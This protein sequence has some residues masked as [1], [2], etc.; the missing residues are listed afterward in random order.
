MQDS[1]PLPLAL[2]FL[3]TW[4]EQLFS[5][6][7]LHPW[8]PARARGAKQ[9]WREISETVSRRRNPLTLTLSTGFDLCTLKPTLL[10]SWKGNKTSPT[11]DII[12]RNP[13][14]GFKRLGSLPKLGMDLTNH[15]LWHFPFNNPPPTRQLAWVESK[16]KIKNYGVLK[17]THIWGSQD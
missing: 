13:W 11:S 9:L 12:S 16:G 4:G 7:P 5:A 3:F 6:V 15:T 8:C 17:Y 10:Y 2:S 14:A 1:R